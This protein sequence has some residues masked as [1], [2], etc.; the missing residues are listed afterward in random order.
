MERREE[1]QAADTWLLCGIPRS[2]SSLCCRLANQLPNTVALSEPID[3]AVFRDTSD[4]LVAARRIAAFVARARERVLEDRLAPSMQVDGRL[5]DQMVAAGRGGAPRRPQGERGMIRIDKRLDAGFVLVVKH[6]ALFAALLPQLTPRFACLGLVRNPV[7]VLASWETVDL[8]VRHG[9]APAAERFD[10]ALRAA[11]N[12]EQDVLRRR[13]LV[14]NW[15]FARYRAMLPKTRIIRYEDVT[16]GGGGVLR[17]TF[18]G[19]G[20]AVESLCNRNASALYQ[21][22]D[23]APLL[24]AL[25]S[26]GGAWTAFYSAEHCR[27]AADALRRAAREA[28]PPT[29]GRFERPQRT[30]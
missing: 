11:L 9:R 24:S 12:G 17:R 15:F 16:R 28:A 14:L 30:P 21:G 18:A 3:N 5:D 10:P 13:V 7:A 22:V 19:A 1:E 6:N 2:G 27:E 20:G 23:A 4:A 29:V 25:L 26:A 8:P